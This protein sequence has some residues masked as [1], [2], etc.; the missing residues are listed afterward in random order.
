MYEQYERLVEQEDSYL[1]QITTV[2]QCVEAILDSL[3]RNTASFHKEGIKDIVS[4]IHQIELNL[5]SDLLHV[6][7]DK[8]FLAYELKKT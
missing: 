1:K 4:M 3:N 2:M 8:A 5:R 6:Q 7:M